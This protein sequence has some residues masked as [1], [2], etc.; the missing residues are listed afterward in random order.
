MAVYTLYWASVTRY[1]IDAA[2]KGV[3]GSHDK[4]TVLRLP[5]YKWDGEEE[6]RVALTNLLLDVCPWLVE[7][8][9]V[10][11]DAA[12]EER[13]KSQL[14]HDSEKQMENIPTKLAERTKN[15]PQNTLPHLVC[16]KLCLRQTAESNN[17]KTPEKKNGDS[18]CQDE[19][20]EVGV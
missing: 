19:D 15:H 11:L 4:L 13:R 20:G 1:Y 3:L 18:S 5:S 8:A 6:D 2:T 14:H 17:P 12:T 9:G 16:K 10:C 7:H